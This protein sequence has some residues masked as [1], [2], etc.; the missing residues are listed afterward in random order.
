MIPAMIRLMP[1]LPKLLNHGSAP[2]ATTRAETPPGR[3]I[4]SGL[5]ALVLWLTTA[6]V[7]AQT[8]VELRVEPN[9]APAGTLLQVH[10]VGVNAICSGYQSSE[11]TQ[12]GFTVTLSVRYGIV[13]CGTPPPVDLV[14]PL[15]RFGPGQYTLVY[16]QITGS[17]TVPIETTGFTV[18]P[19]AS[20]VPAT[21][22]GVL[23]LLAAMLAVLGARY[24][25]RRD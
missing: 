15:G 25:A 22:R 11:V 6:S 3:F 18:Y 5:V 9:P 14:L 24:G 13:A 10:L 7:Q 2:V 16:Q 21:E 20:V 23:L 17:G 1:A 12:Q 19:A 4:R 8:L